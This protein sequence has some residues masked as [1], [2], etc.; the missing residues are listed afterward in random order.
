MRFEQQ[1]KH[2]YLLGALQLA[3]LVLFAVFVRYA[4]D[5]D[6]KYHPAF[7]KDDHH[8]DVVEGGGHHPTYGM[9]QDVHVMIFIGFGFLMTF[10]KKYG[11]G[12]VG[13][14]FLVAAVA[15][16]WAI[17]V[18]GFFHLHDGYVE[19][20]LNSLLGADFVAAAVLIS[21]GA[22]L[23]KT[24][25]AQLLV[26]TIVEIPIF[27]VNEVIGRQYF[28]AVDMGDSMFVH[29]FGAYFG[30]AV[31]LVLARE[32]PSTEKEG[33]SKTSDTFAMI[34]TV[35][36]WIYWPSFNG[37]AAPG[38]DQHRAIINTY[39]ALA[40]SCATAFAISSMVDSDKKFD[41]VHIQNSTL[42]GGVAIGTSADLMA[43]PFGALLIGI[44]AGVVSVLGYHYLTPFLA[45][46]ARIHDTC[47]VHNLHG[48]PAVIAGL[49]GAVYAALADEATYGPSL[50]SIFP[51]RSPL[52]GSEDLTRLQ[53][54]MPS[55]EAGEGRTGV[56]QAGFQLLALLVTLIISI[57]GGLLTGL[58]LR[59][60]M[61]N[62]LETDDLYE[63]EGFWKLE[64]EDGDHM[65]AV[66]LTHTHPMMN[67]A[68]KIKD[69]SA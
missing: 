41:M 33:S 36:L 59:L 55:L 38:E 37:G 68:N 16:Q 22:L 35:F 25:P 24:T 47:G 5:A 15:I 7:D 13:H 31:S 32:V 49:V 52:N 14:N 53:Q 10:L 54:S 51:H 12:A 19:V 29:A 42:A 1:H 56:S 18:N 44:I 20:S 48:M 57:V 34:G 65:S 46:R 61:L 4:P 30:L 28:G 27:M 62:K 26:L 17:L 3:F 60:P 2:A 45:Q 21:F 8:P 50:Y 6:A 23:G 9:F 58:I 39:L 43:Q 69:E 40:A 66:S 67:S 11:F 64:E 63:D